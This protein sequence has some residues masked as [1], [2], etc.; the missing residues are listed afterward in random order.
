[1]EAQ[2][3]LALSDE[4]LLG[5]KWAPGGRVA[6]GHKHDGIN[7]DLH[8]HGAAFLAVH[9]HRRRRGLASWLETVTAFEE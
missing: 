2:G 1:M 9:A 8:V 6:L 7:V 3:L 5:K 4:G